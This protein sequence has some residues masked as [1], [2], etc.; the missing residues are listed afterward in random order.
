MTY[1][2]PPNI[3]YTDMA[4]WIDE[5]AYQDMFD[6]EQLYEYLYHLANMLANKYSY[7]KSAD[8]YDQFALFTA[9]RLYMRL[10]D[11]RQKTGELKEIKSILNYLKAVI[12]PYKIDFDTEFALDNAESACCIYTNVDLSDKLEDEVSIFDQVDLECCIDSI[13]R[14]IRGYLSKIPYKKNSAEWLNIY[15]SC[16]LTLLDSISICK[17]HL[18]KLKKCKI[19]NK[20]LSR[21]YRALNEN[22]PILYHLDKSMSGYIRVLVNEIKQVLSNE[23]TIESR[24][25]IS[26]ETSMKTLICTII[27]ENNGTHFE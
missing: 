11:E 1:I 24:S 6:E 19:D 3:S 12:Y 14:I 26:A 13:E 27:E 17:E 15:T 23:L 16:L 25:H 18:S 4:I 5:H 21:I 9:S 20:A 2:K 10:V 7:F 8:A 22:E